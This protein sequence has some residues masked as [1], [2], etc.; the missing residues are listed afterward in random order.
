MVRRVRLFCTDAL[1]LLFFEPRFQRCVFFDRVSWGFIPGYHNSQLRCLFER[2]GEG[3][4][5]RMTGIHA[6]QP[7]I[8]ANSRKKH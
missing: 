1:L 4:E 2:F 8:N 7:R 3:A 6:G 5:E